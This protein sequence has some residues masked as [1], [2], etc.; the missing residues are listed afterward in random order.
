M[1]IEQIKQG[2]EISKLLNGDTCYS[3][4]PIPI[5]K[6][7]FIRTV[8][9]YYTGRVA[10]VSGG[11]VT[12]EDAAWIADCG[13]FYN[14]LKEGKPNEVEPF[15]NPVHISISSMIDVTEWNHNLPNKQK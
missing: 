8:T 14:F 12:L 10:K 1:D 5:G 15:Q 13:R 11:F 9:M 6:N 2:I 3:D 4:F 7:V